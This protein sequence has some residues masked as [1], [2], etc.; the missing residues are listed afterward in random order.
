MTS[1]VK[2]Q[3]DVPIEW[4][5]KGKKRNRPVRLAQQLVANPST[6]KSDREDPNRLQRR[7]TIS[8]KERAH[9][10]ESVY[11]RRPRSTSV[12]SGQL[13]NPDLAEKE[14]P[15]PPLDVG[16]RHTVVGQGEKKKSLFG[17]L[18]GIIT[19][20]EK[21]H[22]GTG[23]SDNIGTASSA[24]STSLSSPKTP[25]SPSAKSAPIN[26]DKSQ[27]RTRT[28]S[29]TKSPNSPLK[30]FHFGSQGSNI[31]DS[32]TPK[33][34]PT[35]STSSDIGDSR[36][37][38]DQLDPP[39]NH[40]HH[41]HESHETDPSSL[42]SL[43]RVDLR[44]V[45][46]ALDKFH[47]E[48]A[49]QLPSRKPK[50]GDIVVPE[51]LISEEPKISIGI[52]TTSDD[53]ST[54]TPKIP[55]Y[56]KDSREYKLALENYRKLQK[57][58]ERQQQE[59][60]RVAERIANEVTG[61]RGRSGSL[62]GAAQN[63]IV[64]RVLSSAAS[65][66]SNISEPEG[67]SLDARVA[68][69]TIDK[70]IHQHA[71]FF[72]TEGSDS[73]TSRLDTSGTNGI[74]NELPL[75]VV[76]TRCCHLREILPIPSTLRQVKGK[77]APLHTLKF[78]NPKP[79]LIDILSFCD[80]ISITPI[81]VVV[82]DNVN[83]TSD[84]IQIVLSSLINSTAI[85][86][87]GFRN[88]VMN[89]KDW[90]MMCKFIYCNKSIIRLDISQT[91]VKDDLPLECYRHNMNWLLF[92]NVLTERKGR[93]LDELLLNGLRF[94]DIPF[95]SFKKLLLTFASLNKTLNKRLGMASGVLSD[96][97]VSFLFDL[98]SEYDLQGVDLAYNN[99]DP[100]IKIIIEKLSIL[101]FKNL[102][103]FTINGCCI[104]NIQ[105]I[106][107]LL[108]YLSKL[109]KIRFLDLSNLPDMFPSIFAY[110]YKYLPICP[111]LQ[112][113]HFDSN[114]LTYK[115]MIMLCEILQKCPK[116]AHVSMKNQLGFP[117]AIKDQS[118]DA[119]SNFEKTKL[120][121]IKTLG[122]ALY[123]FC[124]D[125]P[126]LLGLDVDYGEISDEI[127]SRVAVTLVLHMNKAIDSNFSQDD[128]TSQ[129]ELL[130]DG[131]VISE[132]AE[133]ILSRLTSFGPNES[134]PTKI[135]LL[136]KFF[137]RLETLH[138]E[139]QKKIDLMFERRNSG[140]LPLKEKEN[141]LRLLL[142]EKNLSNIMKLFAST[143]AAK[144]MTTTELEALQK[145]KSVPSRS[146]SPTSLSPTDVK[147]EHHIKHHHHR[148]FLKHLD[149]DGIFGIGHHNPKADTDTNL[150]PHP[151][152]SES[153]RI[154]DATTGQA[155]LNKNSSSTSLLGKKQEHEE[156]EFH[157][158][159]FFVHQKGTINPVTY[160]KSPT[161]PDSNNTTREN[162]NNNVNEPLPKIIPTVPSGDELRDAII[163]AKGI[164]SIDDLIKKVSEDDHGL[165][166]IYGESLKP[167][168]ILGTQVHTTSTPTTTGNIVETGFGK[169]TNDPQNEIVTE[170]KYDE[171]L[172][173][174]SHNR[175]NRNDALQSN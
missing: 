151:M 3:I 75:D 59:A 34:S 65:S 78:L 165:K 148:P 93:P 30:Y 82:F 98:M 5:Y 43:Q 60:H 38:D 99:L 6:S 175:N 15:S 161:P 111:S 109:P 174:V 130:F 48:P 14:A 158:W 114:S 12:S 166:K 126:T 24:P 26:I 37:L 120:F 91:K 33:Q 142:L 58:S 32:S 13:S 113:I 79:T 2:E 1:L 71:T 101:N 116:L 94:C 83:L 41:H 54:C 57:E 9:L 107:V 147:H 97:C 102:E 16:R 69:L 108:K 74:H 123:G 171:I 138:Y 144:I 50:I 46:F 155:L 45:S 172:N 127:Q 119:S 141:L 90:E 81:Q 20:K 7:M 51:E 153:G 129:D 53:K 115:Q 31:N 49:Q 84:M 17:S 149:S 80:F 133:E 124:R 92:C 76:Y 162:S 157:K 105:H 132:N 150:L 62:F 156:G 140:E 106:G 152:A 117:E 10:S 61:F 21:D 110:L 121:A 136:K 47:H 55:K 70:P 122:A 173:L 27:T 40:Q 29:L 18:F 146:P 19:D 128:L 104:S 163:K 36:R 52:T 4:L 137:E 164:D 68:D 66:D 118:S 56:S 103:Y 72:E 160:E 125:R 112:R 131:K 8:E 35:N 73:S 100:F 44:R 87:L 169:S 170:K 22:H 86:K 139:V 28:A 63:S 154:I 64:N 11:R 23:N 145:V 39:I 67:I 167:F 168:P 25:S 159:G 95:E 77:T 89:P 96:N 143:S 85:E 135:Y 134:D 42:C 88:V